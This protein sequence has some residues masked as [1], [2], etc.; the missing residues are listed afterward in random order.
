MV[1]N[2]M[3]TAGV[4]HFRTILERL[5]VDPLPE[6]CVYTP[7]EGPHPKNLHIGGTP[8]AFTI[9]MIGGLIPQ[10]SS[11]WQV[12]LR[13]PDSMEYEIAGTMLFLTSLPQWMI[14]YMRKHHWFDVPLIKWHKVLKDQ[15]EL[16]FR[17]GML[18][19]NKTD[20]VYLLR[21][22]FN[23]TIRRDLDADWQQERANRCGSAVYKNTVTG[24]NYMEA[25]ARVGYGYLQE[26]VAGM[27]S[28]HD[29][30]S[31]REWWNRRH[32]FMPSG[33]TSA[34][35]IKQMM[36]NDDR[37]GANDRP[38][39]KSTFE[40]LDYDAMLYA[41][42]TAP[43]NA[44]RASTKYEPGNKRRALYASDDVPMLV[45]M[46]ASQNMEKCM[47]IHGI[48][49]RQTPE[50]FLTW[51]NA[52]S[53]SNG[54]W[55]S[56]DY[57]DY[58][59]LHTLEEQE[60]MVLLRA[61]A[62]AHL[63]DSISVEKAKACLWVAKSYHASYIR[64]PDVGWRR[65]ISGMYSGSRDTMAMNSAKHRCDALIALEECQAIG[66]PARLAVPDEIFLAGDDEDTH[67]A[68]LLSAVTYGK[69]LVMMGHD[70]N[71]IKQ[72]AGVQH[73]QYL[74][75]QAYPTSNLQRPLA[76]LIAT[77]ASGNWYVPK[78]TW[79]SGMIN[80][81]SDNMFECV[82][83]GL[84]PQAAQHIATACL[85]TIMR[86]KESDTE[87]ANWIN[88]EWWDFRSP[89]RQHPLWG[90]QTMKPPMLN[91]K[92]EPRKSWPR[93]ATDDWL[94]TQHKLVSLLPARKVTIYTNLLLTDSH[95]AA[96]I[97]FRQQQLRD[98]I[99]VKWPIRKKRIYQ[100]TEVIC[101]VPFGI[102]E[103]AQFYK[104]HGTN[105][106]PKNDSELAARIGID[107][108]LLALVGGW[109]SLP[110]LLNGR[111]W[112][113]YCDV[114]PI[115]ALS[116]RAVASNWAFRSYASTLLG[117]DI[118]LHANNVDT[119]TAKLVYI[120]AGNGAGKTWLLTRYTT[121]MDFDSLSAPYALKRPHYSKD[122]FLGPARD[123]YLLLMCKR[124]L[125]N[126]AIAMLGQWSPAEVAMVMARLGRT[127]EVVSYDPGV[128]V[129]E[130]RL[131][132]RGYD[133]AR[134]THTLARYIPTNPIYKDWREMLL[135]VHEA[136]E[137]KILAPS[138]YDTLKYMISKK[139]TNR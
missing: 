66:Y 115:H 86:V 8:L 82:V 94:A 78:A 6:D 116:A 17:A 90:V 85:D 34:S 4:E 46:F 64:F 1:Y 121:L 75:V 119:T 81:I 53:L 100:H 5:D 13:S 74:Q 102:S 124:A 132:N 22:L 110:S 138:Q 136:T 77:L 19:S 3:G 63:G 120:Y 122:A 70:L 76:S 49:A 98:E 54:Y 97:S 7:V 23:C 131:L 33:S 41:L 52:S 29:Y 96:F 104:I 40:A 65:V 105:N 108:A 107:P 126:N 79:F 24:K 127:V 47:S 68:D 106:A 135:A 71:A 83:R 91:E 16:V 55:V 26:V 92:P 42:R 87:T 38:T 43:V 125:R 15:M 45:G 88:L 133:L 9:S 50:D 2:Q 27:A 37:M 139:D 113:N 57:S 31:Q 67:F 111:E 134:V 62:Y 48:Q 58:N 32:H 95:A 137:N 114:A 73:H 28:R 129:R 89:E 11:I 44:A 101:G 130:S 60:L 21:K 128:E 103:V 59:R 39:K 72:Q 93:N 69:V 10:D 112:S 14:N 123:A 30:A 25:L 118:Q 61:K 117:N 51:V 80:G 99:K 109:D 18:G 56:T 35:W 84:N 20:D 36:R 12:A